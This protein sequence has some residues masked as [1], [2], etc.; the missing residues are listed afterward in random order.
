MKKS[1]MEE[2]GGKK[3]RWGEENKGEKIGR[4]EKG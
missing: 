2:R 3:G 4:E 1:E